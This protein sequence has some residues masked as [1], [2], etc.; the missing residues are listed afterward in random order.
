LKPNVKIIL[1]TIKVS[2]INT[3]KK[4]TGGQ[5]ADEWLAPEGWLVSNTYSIQV[6]MGLMGTHVLT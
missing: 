6:P 4:T 5:Q 1:E 3:N 2:G